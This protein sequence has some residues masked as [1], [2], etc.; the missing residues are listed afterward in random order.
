V[1]DDWGGDILGVATD[2]G[3]ELEGGLRGGRY[4]VVWPRREPEMSHLTRDQFLAV[5]DVEV[6]DGVVGVS[7][8]SFL[9][10]DIQVSVVGSQRDMWVWPVLGTL[11]LQECT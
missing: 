6:R 5:G 11:Y 9:E 4:A 1:D 3:E 7:G 8:H 10:S 2:V